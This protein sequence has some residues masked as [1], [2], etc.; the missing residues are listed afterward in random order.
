MTCHAD[1]AISADRHG[2]KGRRIVSGIHLE[3]GRS[4]GGDSR[5]L[6]Q[7]GAFLGGHHVRELCQ[8]QGRFFAEADDRP[9]RYIVQ[10]NRKLGRVGDT[11]KMPIQTFLVRLVIVRGY[12]QQ[13][14]NPQLFSFHR[15]VDGMSGMVASRPCDDFAASRRMLDGKF[16]HLQFF[17]VGQSRRFSCRPANH[18]TV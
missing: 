4:F 16:E 8:P 14:V 7:R 18:Q 13:S 6:F 15:Q 2:R 10:H 3:T 17:L 9:A 5:H 12:D 11:C 1:D